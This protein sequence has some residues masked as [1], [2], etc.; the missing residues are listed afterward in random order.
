[1]DT[2]TYV[3]TVRDHPQATLLMLPHDEAG[4][5]HLSG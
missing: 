1:V 3:R 4:L 2:L 5:A